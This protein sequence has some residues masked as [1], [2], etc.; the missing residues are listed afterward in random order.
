MTWVA[1]AIGGAAVVGAVASNQG[2]KKQADAAKKGAKL[3]M[4]QFNTLNGQQQ[5]FIQSGYG[6]VSKLN[7]LLGIGG[8]PSGGSP[9]GTG[10]PPVTANAY[11]PRPNGGMQQVIPPAPQSFGAPQDASNLPLKQILTMRAQHGD[12]E[13]QRLLGG[14]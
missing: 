11:Q 7:T 12:T 2:A 5:P 13:A 14:F 9:S 8:P 1:V 10:A 6:A 4:D 3:Q